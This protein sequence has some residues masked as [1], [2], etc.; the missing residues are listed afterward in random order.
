[1]HE[2]SG[3]R[4]LIKVLSNDGYT[5]LE[6]DRCVYTKLDGSDCVIICLYVNDMLIFSTSLEL[7]L[8]QK[9]F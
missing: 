2:N 7:V 3:K 9:V 6:V 1:M 8:K 4:N 5:S